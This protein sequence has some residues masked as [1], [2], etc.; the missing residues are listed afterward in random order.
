MTFL[1]VHPEHK[2]EDA[3]VVSDP[4]QIAVKLGEIDVLFERWSAEPD[5]NPRGQSG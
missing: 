3:L 5:V 4:E 2:P 1:T